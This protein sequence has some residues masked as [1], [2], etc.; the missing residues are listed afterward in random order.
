MIPE[1]SRIKYTLANH[2][3]PPRILKIVAVF[4]SDLYAGVRQVFGSLTRAL[5]EN[6]DLIARS[7]DH[8]RALLSS[9]ESGTPDALL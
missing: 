4:L 8:G 1:T 9:R 7:V 6:V 3:S 5:V 2:G